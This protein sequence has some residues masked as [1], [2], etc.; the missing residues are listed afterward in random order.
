MG[1]TP[2]HEAFTGVL[3]AATSTHHRQPQSPVSSL[4]A[5]P[6]ELQALTIPAS[7]ASTSAPKDL[8]TRIQPPAH[9]LQ[10]LYLVPTSARERRPDEDT[11][12]EDNDRFLIPESV[13]KSRTLEAFADVCSVILPN[14]LF[15]SNL[16]VARD[17]Q[18][19]RELGITHVVNCCQELCQ[20]E[21]HPDTYG[22][23]ATNPASPSQSFRSIEHLR[24]TLRDDT[25]EDL[26]WFFYQVIAFIQ[27]A[28]LSEE[29]HPGRVLVHCHQGIS[30]SCAFV[31]AYIMYQQSQQ[32]GLTPSFRDALAV[33]KAQRPIASPNTAF[34]CQLIEWERELL[35]FSSGGNGSEP[36]CIG[37]SPLYRLAPHAKHDP[38]T[39]VLKPCY[40]P[41]SQ[42]QQVTFD[43]ATDHPK[44]F[45]SRGVFVFVRSPG[46]TG[47]SATGSRRE[48]VIW[49]GRKCEIPNG[50]AV[51]RT[52]VEQIVRL[53]LGLPPAAAITATQDGHLAHFGVEIVEVC[54]EE[55]GAQEAVD[56]FDH[57][58][59]LEELSWLTKS[60]S[61]TV[62]TPTSVSIGDTIAQELPMELTGSL[63]ATSIS[64]ENPPQLF[65]FEGVEDADGDSGSW[66]RLREYDSEDLRPSDVFLLVQ[67]S[68]RDHHF[69]WIGPSC[70][71]FP[72]ETLVKCAQT[73]LKTLLSNGGKLIETIETTKGGEESDAFWTAFEQ[74]F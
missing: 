11:E 23:A 51:A 25:H 16:A 19:L 15:V 69:L 5:D 54:E 33:V 27:N 18:R 6:E 56:P 36:S 32:Q 7:Q 17:P 70:S 3:P 74:G 53:R 57:F 41:G 10:P 21:D 62:L 28:Q 64:T 43:E 38:E 73:H 66:D 46:A 12:A 44:W 9:A 59:Y 50:V 37:N 35:T 63:G 24:L 55:L 30:R 31:V 61:S 58:G 45:F 26:S 1:A 52:H 42:R 47:A 40:V 20:E 22:I 34:L 8:V 68:A 2:S 4:K 48:I 72:V 49:K 39:L 29:S 67:P 65:V 60:S 71:H 13:R 14:F